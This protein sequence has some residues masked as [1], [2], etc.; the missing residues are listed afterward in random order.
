MKEVD[1]EIADLKFPPP[2]PVIRELKKEISK[3]NY[4]PSGNYPELKKAFCDYMGPKPAFAP[5]NVVFGNGLDEI[6]D[7]ISRVWGSSNLI[8]VPTFSQYFQAASRMNQKAIKVNMMRERNYKLHF[9]KGLLRK[10]SLVWIC[11]PNNPTGD[12]IPREKIEEIIHDS[13]GMVVVDECYFE[14]TGKTVL[15]LIGRCKNLIVLRSFSK[16]FGIAGLRLGAAISM[17]ENIKKI[18]RIRQPFNVNR[19][20][21][22]AGPIVLKYKKEYEKIWAKVLRI[23]RK[24]ADDVRKMGY[25]TFDVNANYILVDFSSENSAREMF[26]KLNKNRIKACAGWSDEFDGELNGCIRFAI[27]SENNMRRALDVLKP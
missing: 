20:A 23:G 7:L 14:Y 6:I 5:E 26:A 2:L 11:N 17:P 10:A 19:M 18:E 8:P 24:F 13:P 4:Y 1:L 27:S 16:N 9:D 3:I 12:L 21:E 25:R 15:D 22:K